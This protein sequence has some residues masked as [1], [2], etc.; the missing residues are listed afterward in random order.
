[1]KI[2]ATADGQRVHWIVLGLHTDAADGDGSRLAVYQYC[3]QNLN[4]RA[5][6]DVLER[7]SGGHGRRQLTQT[8]ASGV[9]QQ[10]RS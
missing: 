2:R 8:Q 3:T 10:P 4:N 9:V 1:M 6:A 5:E 7:G